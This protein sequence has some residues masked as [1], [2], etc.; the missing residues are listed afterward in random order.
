MHNFKELL[1]W[2]KAVDLA[3]KIYRVTEIF[4]GN[5]K[6]NLI[7]QM[8]RAAVSIP[9]NSSEGCG[10]NTNEILKYFLG[11]ALGSSYELETQIILSKRIGYI[12]DTAANEIE[13]M[14]IEV[15]KMLMGLI[16][17]F[18]NTKI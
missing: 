3:E 8:Q 7:T 14:T 12:N 18:Q 5:E 11:I 9:S 16:H 17:S 6:F 2:K 13:I 1:V 4:P 10:R 15:Q